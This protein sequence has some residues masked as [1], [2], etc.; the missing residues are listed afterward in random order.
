MSDEE[1]PERPK[2]AAAASTD[3]DRVGYGRPPK[4]T[5]FKP[6][7]SGNRKGRPKGAKGFKQSVAAMLNERIKMRTKD[8]RTVSIRS[9]DASLRAVRD[10][11][12]FKGNMRALD[13]MI[14]LDREQEERE[15]A[16]TY[17]AKRDKLAEEDKALIRTALARLG[18]NPQP[19][20]KP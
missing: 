17:A 9:G 6:G 11:G 19:D 4:H 16:K 18:I 15:E 13:R 5:R 14:E 3:D 10:Q 7:Q 12:L 20:D 2:R 8:G 1:A